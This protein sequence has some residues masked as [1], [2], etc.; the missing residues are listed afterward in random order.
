MVNLTNDVW[1][2]NT[3]E[4]WIHL[5]LAKFRAIEHRRFFVR[6]TN[7]GISAFIDPV[8]RV[9]AQ[10]RPLEEQT[11]VASVAWLKGRTVY[12]VIG[13]YPCHLATVVIALAAHLSRKRHGLA[14]NAHVSPRS[15]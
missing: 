7:S 11:L 9:L 12:E 6:S 8:G 14:S 15:K 1:F 2:G 3:T 10:S 5:A 13:D 4:P